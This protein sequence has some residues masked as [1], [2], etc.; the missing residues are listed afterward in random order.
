M[1]SRRAIRALLLTLLSEL[2]SFVA[3]WFRSRGALQTENLFL[4]KQLAFYREHQVRPQPLTDDARVSLVVWSRFCDWKN[5]LMIVKPE[6]LIAWHGKG[7]RLFWR[8]KSRPGRPPRVHVQ[9]WIPCEKSAWPPHRHHRFRA[10]AHRQETCWPAS[11]FDRLRR[12]RNM[13]LYDD[14]GFVSHHD[15]E[16][17]LESAG[18]YLNVIRADIANRRS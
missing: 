16:Q 13:A 3:G 5:A 17:A 14:T 10:V 6:A 1:R 2:F 7:F 4:R 12:K 11:R 15:A 8:W 18:D 9:P